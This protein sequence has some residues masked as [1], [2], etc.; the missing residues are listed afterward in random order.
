MSR[1]FGGLQYSLSF[2]VSVRVW[3]STYTKSHLGDVDLAQ[4]V[5]ADG[6]SEDA[7]A[8]PLVHRD[9]SDLVLVWRLVDGDGIHLLT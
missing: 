2:Q 7:G 9:L 6:N 3:L 4:G 1:S 5:I 8:I